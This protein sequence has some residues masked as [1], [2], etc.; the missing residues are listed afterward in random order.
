L[1]KARWAY[2]EQDWAAGTWDAK[3]YGI[4]VPRVVWFKYEVGAFVRLSS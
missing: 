3:E 2:G 4:R 1:L